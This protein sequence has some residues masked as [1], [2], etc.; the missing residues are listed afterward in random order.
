MNAEVLVCGALHQLGRIDLEADL[1][2]PL[3]DE[4]GELVLDPVTNLPLPIPTTIEGI[5]A[6]L[7]SGDAD[8]V[9]G[10]D[11]LNG[12][13]IADYQELV[14]ALRGGGGGGGAGVSL[15]GLPPVSS[16]GAP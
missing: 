6:R 9:N 10:P 1:P 5:C 16:A 3:V 13:G 14:D 7:L 8:A 15:P 2:V 11:D 12:N 4:L